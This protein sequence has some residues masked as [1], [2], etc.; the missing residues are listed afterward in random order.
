MYVLR[1][2][3]YSR[4]DSFLFWCSHC[5]A[6][7]ACSTVYNLSHIRCGMT[8]TASSER[9]ALKLSNPFGRETHVCA[10]NIHPR[11]KETKSAED[12]C[13]KGTFHSSR[14]TSYL[15][16]GLIR[17]YAFHH[18]EATKSLS[19]GFSGAPQPQTTLPK[20]RPVTRVPPANITPFDPVLRPHSRH[21]LPLPQTQWP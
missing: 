10:R 8:R 3:L 5:F 14:L 16:E 20:E 17:D 1:F 12:P 19:R 4:W 13:P 18:S 6:F 21:Y 11:S 7:I 9:A 15:R 2:H